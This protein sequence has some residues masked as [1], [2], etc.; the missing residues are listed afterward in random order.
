MCVT[1][2]CLHKCPSKSVACCSIKRAKNIQNWKQK[3]SI[4]CKTFIWCLFK[5]RP[6]VQRL[7]KNI[8]KKVPKIN[9]FVVKDFKNVKNLNL[10][11]R[12]ATAFFQREALLGI[13]VITVNRGVTVNWGLTAN[14]GITGAVVSI[15]R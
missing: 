2:N 5:K 4:R 9:V 14:W 3:D 13:V 6:K 10:I 11:M 8:Y 7:A 12:C 1:L 15:G